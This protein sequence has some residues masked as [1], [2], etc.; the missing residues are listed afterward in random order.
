MKQLYGF[1]SEMALLI[2]KFK[3]QNLH[4]SIILYGP[5]G[6]GKR[7]FV[8]KLIN[9]FFENLFKNNSLNH[10][11]NLYKNNTHPNI[12]IVE[13][14]VDNKT[15]KI[16]SLISIEQIR[17]IN[18]FTKQTSAVDNLFKVVVVDSIDDLSTS[19]ANSFLKTLEEPKKNTFLFLISHQ[20]S[21]LLPTLRSRCL[22]IKFNN[23]DYS[24]FKNIIY[25]HL[26]KIT[27][28]DF[29]FLFEISNFSPGKAI[30]LYD[31]NIFNLLDLSIN[32]LDNSIDYL[33]INELSNTLSKLDDEK[34]NN[35][36]SILKSI[37]L[38]LNNLKLQT[39][40]NNH[41]I[42][43]KFRQLDYLSTKIPIKTLLNKLEFLFKNE[44]DLFALNLDK[45]LFFLNFINS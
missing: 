13:K 37:L 1:E 30:S 42:S 8:N 22:K 38:L 27:E 12:K 18:K 28:E 29:Y 5:K 11:L 41:L 45:K 23:H 20:I 36:I 39:K 35:Y 15:K 14:L 26:G 40:K 7:T 24:I 25:D 17:A 21:T 16:K 34:F 2:S 10:H 3:N 32:C 44:K 6:I 43:K 9:N 31:K 4:N 33:K 19:A